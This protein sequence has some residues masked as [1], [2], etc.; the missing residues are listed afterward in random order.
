[1]ATKT[2][3]FT[4][5]RK[6]TLKF[7]KYNLYNKSGKKKLLGLQ[8]LSFGA[9]GL[10]YLLAPVKIV[11]NELVYQQKG[12]D[13]QIEGQLKFKVN[14]R[15]SDKAGFDKSIKDK[16]IAL[17]SIGF[18]TDPTPGVEITN[19][20]MSNPNKTSQFIEIS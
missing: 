9:G 13:I 2:L 3:H 20:T 14:V 11:K 19:F 10:S 8:S 6:T 7:D 4:F 17:R 16:S 18:N 1:M 5:L 15:D 12:K